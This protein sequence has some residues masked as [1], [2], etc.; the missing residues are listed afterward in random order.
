MKTLES[1]NILWLK[2]KHIPRLIVNCNSNIHQVII[3]KRIAVEIFHFK[4]YRDSQSY[5]IND[6]DSGSFKLICS[7]EMYS[8][9]WSFWSECIISTIC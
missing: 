5:T 4:S 9:N 2:N 7:E 3:Q 1:Q 6:A 8:V